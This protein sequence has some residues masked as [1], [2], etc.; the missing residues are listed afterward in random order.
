MIDPDESALP[1]EK[2]EEFPYSTAFDRMTWGNPDDVVGLV[3]YALYKKMIRE[4]V[5][6]G[7]RPAGKAKNPSK[8]TVEFYRS[9]AQQVLQTFAANAIDEAIPE[10]QQSALFDRF[11]TMGADLRRHISDSTSPGRA[12]WTSIV[13]WIITIALTFLAILIL[14]FPDLTS[15][16][17]EVLPAAEVTQPETPH[18]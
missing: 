10:I 4:E 8:A 14:R 12:I 16:L 18:R 11:E 9:A 15:V 1:P 5:L 13:G 2:A 3:A 6:E 17:D 7:I